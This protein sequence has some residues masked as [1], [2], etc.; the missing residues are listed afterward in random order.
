MFTGGLSALDGVSLFSYFPLF[1]YFLISCSTLFFR[2]AT[3]RQC[4]TGPQTQKPETQ[5]PLFAGGRQG[6]TPNGPFFFEKEEG[7]WREAV[8]LLLVPERASLQIRM[9]LCA[10]LPQWCPSCWWGG[11]SSESAC[12]ASWADCFPTVKERHPEVA[13]ML[14]KKE[15]GRRS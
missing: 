9:T 11:L 8:T 12:W 1:S 3:V 4:S 13:E 6:G 10:P 5:G 14:V 15:I 7:G 2:G